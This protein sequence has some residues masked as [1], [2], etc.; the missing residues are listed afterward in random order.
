MGLNCGKTQLR[1]RPSVGYVGKV[2]ISDF[3]LHGETKRKKILM[4][5]E[6]PVVKVC[7]KWRLSDGLT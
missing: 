3:L 1:L 4:A 2:L 6:L 5:T 7:S